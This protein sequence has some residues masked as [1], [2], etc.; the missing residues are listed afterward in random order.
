MQGLPFKLSLERY[1]EYLQVFQK[2]HQQ[3]ISFPVCIQ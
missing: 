1:V 3:K 2:D